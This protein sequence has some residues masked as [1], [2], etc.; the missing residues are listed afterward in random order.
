M[1]NKQTLYSL[2][3]NCYCDSSRIVYYD[4]LRRHLMTFSDLC[5]SVNFISQI[6]NDLLLS[7]QNIGCLIRPSLALPAVILG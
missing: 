3:G 5:D 1:Q 6:L 4:G 2:C 7:E